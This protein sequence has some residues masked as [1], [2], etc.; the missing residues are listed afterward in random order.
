[1]KTINLPF[2]DLFENGTT[3]CIGSGT[4]AIAQR[5]NPHG[6]RF[7]LDPRYGSTFCGHHQLSRMGG[8][9]ETCFDAFQRP[10]RS[11]P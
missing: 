10:A 3:L 6:P 7:W 11:G 8:T 5:R 2:L 1:M 4:L 9:A